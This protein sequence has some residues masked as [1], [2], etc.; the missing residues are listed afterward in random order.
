MWRQSARGLMPSD[1]SQ[2]VPQVGGPPQSAYERIVEEI[3]SGRL[4]PGSKLDLAELM[5]RYF[6]STAELRETIIHLSNDGLASLDGA[7]SLRIAPVSLADLADLTDSRILIETEVAR[8]SV[9]AGDAVWVADLG[10]SF[11][12]LAE[13]EPLR[14][15]EQRSHVEQW[16]RCN[17]AF[18]A[19]LVSAC[20]VLRLKEISELLYRQHER[21]RRL[22]GGRRLFSRE[23]LSEH[24]ELY[25]A[26]LARD[27]DGVARLLGDHIRHTAATL[28]DG[29]S[30]GSWFGA[31][32]G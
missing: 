25:T 6:T 8:R 15:G 16:E 32:G 31:P 1:S 10:Q 14:T 3:L 23:A 11:V 2:A 21:Y 29:L 24:Q 5:R 4:A 22:S 27:G 26:A 13:M 17:H 12:R 18:H 7:S 30:D 19:A 20:P 28:A 9:L